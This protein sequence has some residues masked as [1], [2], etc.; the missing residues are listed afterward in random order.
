MGNRYHFPQIERSAN[1]NTTED[2]TARLTSSCLPT[3]LSPR[4]DLCCRGF[5]TSFF[6]VFGGRGIDRFEKEQL[7]HLVI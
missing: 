5:G 4:P 2:P 1:V 7:S 6:D 3:A